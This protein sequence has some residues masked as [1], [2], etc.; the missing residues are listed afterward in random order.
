MRKNIIG[1]SS[2]SG[3]GISKTKALFDHLSLAYLYFKTGECLSFY[4]LT[5]KAA[6]KDRC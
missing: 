5:A 3:R 4:A 2:T 1:F 6:F